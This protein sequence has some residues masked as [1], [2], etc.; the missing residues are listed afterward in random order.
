MMMMGM[1]V[2]MFSNNSSSSVEG[3]HGDGTKKTDME[4]KKNKKKSVKKSLIF[5]FN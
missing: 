5:I 2:V 1:L 4:L 3:Q